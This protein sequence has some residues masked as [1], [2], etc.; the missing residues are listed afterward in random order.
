MEVSKAEQ[1]GLQEQREALVF[2][3]LTGADHVEVVWRW[4]LE[5]EQKLHSMKYELR[6]L[7]R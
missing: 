7:I 3:K 4:H 5:D 2:A 1:R 6:K